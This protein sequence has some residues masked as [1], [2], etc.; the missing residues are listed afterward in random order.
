MN[1]ALPFPVLLLLGRPVRIGAVD[2]G[3][4]TDVLASPGLSHVLGFEV[5][6]RHDQARV[7]P[8]VAAVLDGEAVRLTSVFSL[9]SSSELSLYLDRGRRLSEYEEELAVDYDGLLRAALPDVAA[10]AGPSRATRSS[11]SVHAVAK[12]SIP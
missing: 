12:R 4:I 7:V 8:W 10:A 9:L 1:R 3:T 11:R 6:T 5:R 2:V